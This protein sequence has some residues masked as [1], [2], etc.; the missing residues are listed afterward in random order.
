MMVNFLPLK[1]YFPAA[2]YNTEDIEGKQTYNKHAY[3]PLLCL[4]LY[5]KKKNGI[6]V[7]VTGD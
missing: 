1:V 6:Y 3:T 2:D 4:S 7:K 5:S